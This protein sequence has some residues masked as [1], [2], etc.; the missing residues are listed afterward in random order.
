VKKSL[1]GG[2]RPSSGAAD[3]LSFTALSNSHARALTGVAAPGDGRTPLRYVLISLAVFLPAAARA[4]AA[5]YGQDTGPM[6]QGMNWGILSLL[7]IIL[8]V[9]GSV[10][11]FFIYLARRSVYVPATAMADELTASTDKA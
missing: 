10:A 5:C 11:G 3:F 9:L 1:P 7:G 4:C 6:A 8:L 2:V